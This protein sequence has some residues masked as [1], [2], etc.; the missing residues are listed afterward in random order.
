MQHLLRTSSDNADFRSLV[1]LL[2]QDLAVRN[3]ADNDFY[4][5]Y[6]QVDKLRHVVVAYRRQEG[7]GCGAFKEFEPGVVEIKR[8][9]V[10]PAQ[11]G[12]GIAQAVLAELEQWAREL[13]YSACVLETGQQNPEAIQL[14]QKS[15]YSPIPNYGQYAGVTNS[16]CMRKAL[17]E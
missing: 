12:R 15:G 7:V 13:K 14:Y 5:Q 17:G 1:T 16:V 10:V 2:D 9:F 3:G 6:N 11:R 4:A 8:M